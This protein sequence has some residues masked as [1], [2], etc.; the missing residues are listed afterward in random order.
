MT[1]EFDNLLKM[2]QKSQTYGHVTLLFLEQ[3][4]SNKNACI[5]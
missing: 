4:F 5:R 3:E 2:T 1:K